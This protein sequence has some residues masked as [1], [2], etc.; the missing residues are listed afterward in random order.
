M[1]VMAK[2]MLIH[3]IGLWL[4]K[5]DIYVRP[6]VLIAHL[7]ISGVIEN[8][9]AFLC[10]LLNKVFGKQVIEILNI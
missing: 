1:V 2:V 6:E 3:G 4:V 8:I 10:V 5:K 9:V 7:N